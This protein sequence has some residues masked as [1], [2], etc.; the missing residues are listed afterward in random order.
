VSG[1]TGVGMWLARALGDRQ[2]AARRHAP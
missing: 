2:A 1:I